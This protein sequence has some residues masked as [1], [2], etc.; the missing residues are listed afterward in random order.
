M[1]TFLDLYH[2]YREGKLEGNEHDAMEQILSV[3][4][5]GKNIANYFMEIKRK[6]RFHAHP[7]HSDEWTGD[8]WLATYLW[9]P[10][11]RIS[12]ITLKRWEP[13]WK[14]ALL[15]NTKAVSQLTTPIM[16]HSLGKR[17]RDRMSSTYTALIRVRRITDV[18]LLCPIAVTWRRDPA[19]LADE[20]GLAECSERTSRVYSSLLQAASDCAGNKR[21]NKRTHL[22]LHGTYFHDFSG[23]ALLVTSETAG[24]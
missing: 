10:I 9:N 1:Y 13:R 22:I 17:T 5:D 19:L 20:A 3:K 16:V 4:V 8:D 24:S 18:Y 21:I 6:A 11:Q 2:Q 23:E 15:V 7:P 14:H 12:S